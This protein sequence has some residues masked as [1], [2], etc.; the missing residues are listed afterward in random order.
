[1]TDT[2]TTLI[3]QT[4]NYYRESF[5]DPPYCQKCRM[6][7]ERSKPQTS[8]QNRYEM[9]LD[10]AQ[11]MARALEHYRAVVATVNN[12]NDWTPQISDEGSHARCALRMWEAF[13]EQQI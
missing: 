7:S 6:M 3:C 13:R 5:D 12:P 8:I 2:K 10:V 1:M 9:L 11:E 4:H